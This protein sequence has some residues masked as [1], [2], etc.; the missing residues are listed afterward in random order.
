MTMPEYT[1]CKDNAL[2]CDENCQRCANLIYKKYIERAPVVHGKWVI[3]SD[4]YYPYCSECKSEP[5]N[6]EMTDYCPNC[7]AKMMEAK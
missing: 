5:K 6:G 7:G 1:L 2:C 3:S 4:G